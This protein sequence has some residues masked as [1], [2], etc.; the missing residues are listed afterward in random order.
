MR[1]F[2]ILVLAIFSG[3]MFVPAASLAKTSSTVQADAVPFARDVPITGQ[4]KKGREFK[5]TFHI[6]EFA[7][8]DG[9]VVAIGDL[10]G[11][12]KNKGDGNG[13]R[14]VRK[15]NVA[16]PVSATQGT[17]LNSTQACNIV[18]LLLGPLD[19]NIL[20]LRV[21]LNQVDLDITGVPGTGLL[22]D[23][24]CGLLGPNPPTSGLLAALNSLLSGILGILNLGLPVNQ[25]G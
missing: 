7:E 3:A 2:L 14:K 11:R 5:G 21:Q 25:T 4:T 8:R 23:L 1:L 15:Y 9:N 19:L 22:G 20:G 24:L 13:W 12:L 17:A 18:N 16:L 6:D 10:K